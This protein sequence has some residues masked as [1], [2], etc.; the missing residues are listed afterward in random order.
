MANAVIDSDGSIDCIMGSESFDHEADE[1]SDIELEYN[2]ASTTMD[3][4]DSP[5]FGDC[6]MWGIMTAGA[7]TGCVPV[8]I[9]QWF[10]GVI[11]VEW[12]DTTAH[13]DDDMAICAIGGVIT[14]DD[15]GTEIEI[16]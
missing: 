6:I 1:A 10:A 15:A 5:D 12:A 7:S 13:G 4:P 11:N 2:T 16:E 9:P 8:I 14:V 3:M